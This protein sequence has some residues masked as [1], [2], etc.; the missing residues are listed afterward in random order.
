MTNPLLQFLIRWDRAPTAEH[1]E[2]DLAVFPIRQ[3][4]C[5]ESHL[6]SRHS[7]DIVLGSLQFAGRNVAFVASSTPELSRL[8]A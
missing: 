1:L 6:L 2:I 7:H 3:I 8:P 4:G 5:L